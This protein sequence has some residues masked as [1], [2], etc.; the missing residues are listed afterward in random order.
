MLWLIVSLSASSALAAGCG[1]DRG[2]PALAR[3]D[4]APLVALAHRIAGEGQCA[5][6]R[7]I[8]LLRRRAIS[9]A[10]TGRVPAELEDTFLS[11]VNALAADAPPCLPAVPPVQPAAP[12]PGHGKGHGHGHRH[13]KGKD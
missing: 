6:L 10:N 4:A 12:P 2:P 3:S 5:Q 7:D 8:R 9:L 11:G 1:G 13:G